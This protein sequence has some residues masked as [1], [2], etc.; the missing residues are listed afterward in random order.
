M[1][2]IFLILILMFG[3][4]CFS[5]ISFSYSEEFDLMIDVMGISKTN[6]H[7]KEINEDIYNAYSLF[8]YGNPLDGYEGQRFKTVD[9]GKWTQDAG[10]WNGSGIRGEYWI[11]RRE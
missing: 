6:I 8:V 10:I 7:G 11:L 3:I 9:D 4:T 5:T 1:K 2:K